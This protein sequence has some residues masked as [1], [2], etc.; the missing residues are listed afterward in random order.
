MPGDVNSDGNVNINDVTALIDYMLTG[1]A[2]TIDWDNANLN[3]DDAVNITDLTALI[4]MMIGGSAGVM[5]K[6]G[7]MRPDPA[8]MPVIPAREPVMH[9]SRVI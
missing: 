8:S 1:N 7:N 5:K 2:G 3:G 9:K 4:D 6:A